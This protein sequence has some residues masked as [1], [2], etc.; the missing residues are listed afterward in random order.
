MTRTQAE[1]LES[2][3]ALPDRDRRELV[4]HLVQSNLGGESFLKRMTAEQRAELLEGIAQAD[5]GEVSPVDEVFDRITKRS[6][7]SDA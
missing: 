4:E 5:R 7:G 3:A 2:I 1:I 6:Q